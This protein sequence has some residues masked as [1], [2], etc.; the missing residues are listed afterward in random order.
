MTLSFTLSKMAPKMPYVQE[1][2]PKGGYPQIPYKRHIPK[3]GLTTAGSFFFA[4]GIMFWNHVNMK[5]Q[6]RVWMQSE[7][8]NQQSMVVWKPLFQAESE[9][10]EVLR[11]M[12]YKEQVNMNLVATGI[13]PNLD[14]VQQRG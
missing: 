11:R 6:Q 7:M 8:E 4:A 9:R 10:L 13:F 3:R 1:M 14:P 12:N 5:I 2:P